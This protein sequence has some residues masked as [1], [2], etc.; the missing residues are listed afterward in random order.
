MVSVSG[1]SNAVFC[2]CGSIKRKYFTPASTP[3]APSGK[4]HSAWKISE[5]QSKGVK[6]MFRTED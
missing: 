4:R 3:A 6:G 5:E 2:T 1:Y